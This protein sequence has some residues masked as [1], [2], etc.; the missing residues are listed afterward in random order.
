MIWSEQIFGYGIDKNMTPF[1]DRLLSPRK[2][3]GLLKSF[4]SGYF[5]QK[6]FALFESFLHFFEKL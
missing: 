1:F 5:E 3:K 2:G 6:V 4:I